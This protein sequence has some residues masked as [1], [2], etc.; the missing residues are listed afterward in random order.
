MSRVFCIP[1]IIIL[2]GAFV[3]NLLVSLSLPY[4]T[5]I[6]ITRAHFN[7]SVVSVNT[8]IRSIRLGVWS[9]CE[10]NAN[11]TKTCYPARNAYSVSISE[12]DSNNTK[13][14]ITIGSAWTRG[15]AI[16]PVA[17]GVTFV[18]LLSSF[19]TH[20]TVTLISSL[21]SFFGALVTL[22]AFAVDIALF[23][24][25]R[26]EASRL[27]AG[28]DTKPGPG[29]WMTLVAFILLLLAGCTVCFG[30]RRQRMSSAAYQ[31]TAPKTP[32]WSRFRRNKQ[33]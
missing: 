12:T 19:S 20:I 24:Y 3:L 1:G 23:V 21:L 17:A 5:D 33:F 2:F 15:L 32:F 16:H 7:E 22:I 4:L 14:S 28:S 26:H 13:E 31:T 9:A 25:F 11:D 10:Y 30:R 18:A 27:N 8:D 6:D 29:F